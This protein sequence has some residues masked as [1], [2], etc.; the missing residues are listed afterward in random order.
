MCA[1]FTDL[2]V[3]AIAGGTGTKIVSKTS[4]APADCD[5]VTV[6][7]TTTPG[8]ST[9]SSTLAP[10]NPL[11]QICFCDPFAQD[12]LSGF[13]CY[14]VNGTMQ[15]LPAGSGGLFAGCISQSSCA[16]GFFCQSLSMGNVCTPICEVG[17]PATCP[18]GTQCTPVSGSGITTFG[19]CTPATVTT[20]TSSTTST[21]PVCNVFTQTCPSGQGCYPTGG[22]PAAQCSNQGS[23]GQGSSCVSSSGCAAGYLC[24]VDS[25][26]GKC[27]QIC[28]IGGPSTCTVGTCSAV[29]LSPSGSPSNGTIPNLGGCS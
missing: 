14:P 19:G 10:C 2:I 20:T 25:L 5:D 12:C 26:L 7:T 11:V 17:G 22:T 16:A 24:A 29:L 21:V 9:T 15:C 28:E 23:G 8:S 1:D 3:K 27:R 13:G 18:S 4:A 6:T